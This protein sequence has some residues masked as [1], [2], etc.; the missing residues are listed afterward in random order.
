MITCMVK[1]TRTCAE[2]LSQSSYIP[3]IRTKSTLAHQNPRPSNTRSH[4]CA[5]AHSAPA[6]HASFFA[7]VTSSTKLFAP[8][9]R[10]QK[11]HSEVQAMA[12]VSRECFAGVARAARMEARR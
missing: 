3:N 6:L 5:S 12:E 8:V 7:A 4:T 1:G 10:V 11:V 2:T 9:R